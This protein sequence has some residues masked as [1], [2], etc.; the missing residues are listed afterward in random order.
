MRAIDGQLYE[1]TLMLANAEIAANKRADELDTA[2]AQ[3]KAD[4]MTA[5]GA[6]PIFTGL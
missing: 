2:L 3:A 6:L 4:L 1:R 5:S